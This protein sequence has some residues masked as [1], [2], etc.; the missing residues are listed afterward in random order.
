MFVQS[1]A[2]PIPTSITAKSTCIKTNRVLL[3]VSTVYIHSCCPGNTKNMG[4]KKIVPVRGKK[5][6]NFYP[7]C[8]TVALAGP[9]LP[10]Q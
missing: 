3:Y 10:K 7:Q 5:K 1:Y 2:P 9:I 8:V 6:D 4:R